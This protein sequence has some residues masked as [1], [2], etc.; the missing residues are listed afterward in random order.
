M[1]ADYKGI[2]MR[3]RSLRDDHGLS[4]EVF[5]YICGVSQAAA[6]AWERSEKR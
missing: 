2:A 4:Q 1:T 3:L 5:G 6:S